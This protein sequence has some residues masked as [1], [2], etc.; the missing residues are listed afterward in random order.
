MAANNDIVLGVTRAADV[1]KHEAAV[2]RLEKLA[3]QATGVVAKTEQTAEPASAW[4]TELQ[5]AASKTSRP[6]RF[7]SA[8]GTTKAA[9]AHDKK[10]VYVQFE[11]LLLKNMV[12]A[13]MPEDAEAV[14]GSGT[15]GKMWKSM[16]AEKIA[17]EIARSGSIGIAKQVAAGEAAET[18]KAGDA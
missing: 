13:M 6:A 12:E 16:L 4:S 15:A 5:V 10:D 2:S 7:V 11:A 18:K 1:A 14:F 3:G 9:P 8:A 17:E